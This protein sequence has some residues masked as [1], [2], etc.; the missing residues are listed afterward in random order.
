MLDYKRLATQAD[1]CRLCFDSA[2]RPR[3]LTVAVATRAYLMLPPGAPLVPG[4]A[5]IV[6]SAHDPSTRAADEAT[7]EEMRNFKKC[8]LRMWAAE[9]KDVV[10]IESAM[11][12]AAQRGH[13]HVEAIPV[14]R[15]LAGR[16][17]GMFKKAIDEAEV[18]PALILFSG[19]WRG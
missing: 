17:P 1:R 14:P 8:L 15:A 19:G 3:Q 5:V 11:G 13:A 12:L 16:A 10:F 4:H 7:W 9:G 6:A 18:W 2:A